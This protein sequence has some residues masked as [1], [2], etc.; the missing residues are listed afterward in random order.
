MSKGNFVRFNA[1]NT[2]HGTEQE[3]TA[4]FERTNNGP[5]T[6]EQSLDLGSNQTNKPP[7][8]TEQSK[9]GRTNSAGVLLPPL[10][11]N[12]VRLHARSRGLV[13]AKL[14]S[15]LQV[16]QRIREKVPSA[17]GLANLIQTMIDCQDFDPDEFRERGLTVAAD[18]RSE[19]VLEGAELKKAI[20]S[21]FVM[22]ADLQ[23][24]PKTETAEGER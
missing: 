1:T 24:H 6:N 13:L 17:A 2:E 3:R 4:I 8:R 20:G 12:T 18:C 23:S 11:A 5:N 22:V 7:N 14:G 10:G 16:C 19:C 21:N 15:M 9:T